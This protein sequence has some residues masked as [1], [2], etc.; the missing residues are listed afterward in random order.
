LV[1]LEVWPP[2]VGFVQKEIVCVQNIIPDEL[3]QI[4]VNLVSAGFRDDTDVSSRRTAEGCIVEPG[5]DFELFLS[6]RVGN[7]NAAAG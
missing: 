7:R 3:E 1:L 6:V 5:L 4:P 2:L